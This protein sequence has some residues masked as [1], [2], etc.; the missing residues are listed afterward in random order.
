MHVQAMTIADITNA[1]GTHI[2]EDY[3]YASKSCT[4]R[5]L[6]W[7]RKRKITKGL[8]KLWQKALMLGFLNSIEYLAL[9]SLLGHWTETPEWDCWWNDAENR[10]F[11]A[12]EH[13]WRIWIPVPRRSRRQRYQPTEITVPSPSGTPV[14]CY[15]DRSFKVIQSMTAFPLPTIELQ[16]DLKQR[17]ENLSTPER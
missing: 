8:T 1:A 17:I 6:I 15:S 3:F 7:P 13:H 16:Q 14:S 10:L 4:T 11:I 2:V 12:E 9:K 5:K